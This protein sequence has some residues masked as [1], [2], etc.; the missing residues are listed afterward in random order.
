MFY[1]FLEFNI[2]VILLNNFPT[3]VSPNQRTEPARGLLGII[4]LIVSFG[5]FFLYLI[6]G[7]NGRKLMKAF[8][9]LGAEHIYM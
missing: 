1:T 4:L 5:T 2:S 6:L 3:W 9:V 7:E 8:G